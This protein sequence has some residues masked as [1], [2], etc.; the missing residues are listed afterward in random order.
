MAALLQRSDVTWLDEAQ[1]SLVADASDFADIDTPE[2]LVRLG[3]AS[4]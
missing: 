1:W 3:L 2:D 4:R